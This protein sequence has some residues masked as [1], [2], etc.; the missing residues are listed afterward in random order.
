MKSFAWIAADTSNLAA[1]GVISGTSA[2]IIIHNLHSLSHVDA[3]WSA[4][5]I[6]LV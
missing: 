2:G 1:I 4:P 6:Y 5:R 3:A